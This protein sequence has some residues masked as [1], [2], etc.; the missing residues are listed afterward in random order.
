MLLFA[1]DIVSQRLPRPRRS[2]GDDPPGQQVC[3]DP[4]A[5]QLAQDEP[6]QAG[7]DHDDA[8]D[9]KVDS[10]VAPGRE[11]EPEDRS[12]REEEDAQAGAQRSPTP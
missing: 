6:E 9:M 11:R 8:D 12:G 7:A 10:E 5:R 2:A 3:I 4:H 1:E